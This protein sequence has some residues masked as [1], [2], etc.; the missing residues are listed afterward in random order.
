MAIKKSN[1]LGKAVYQGSAGNSSKAG[2]SF[3]F[4]A[5]AATTVIEGR[6]FPAGC[7]LTGIEYINAALGASVTIDVK[8]GDATL[9]AG[10]SCAAAG[11]GYKPIEDALTAVDNTTLSLVVGGAAATGKVT[12]R[13]HYEVVGTL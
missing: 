11:S 1:L 4:A 3:T 13:A 5:D 2:F 7:K 6:Q 10:L 9:I 12:F 8:L